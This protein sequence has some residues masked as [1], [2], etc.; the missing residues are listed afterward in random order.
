MGSATSSSLNIVSTSTGV[1]PRHGITGV[2]PTSG[3]LRI[4]GATLGALK[5][6]STES[7]AQTLRALCAASACFLLARVPA[8]LRYRSVMRDHDEPEPMP[9]GSL[10][11]SWPV[12]SVER[13]RR[14]RK[15]N[16][17]VHMSSVASRAPKK[18]RFGLELHTLA[19]R[20][21]GTTP[22]RGRQVWSAYVLGER[23]GFVD[24]M[25]QPRASGERSPP[26][27]VQR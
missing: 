25:R 18:C 15:S 16:T 4:I 27:G 21:Q 26:V 6:R 2:R 5:R 14:L 22:R 7:G 19:G 13:L 10:L 20:S 23:A 17:E 11:R 24:A 3:V 9:K 1:T 12:S 8:T